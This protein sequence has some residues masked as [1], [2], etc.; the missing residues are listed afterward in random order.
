[1]VVPLAEFIF[2]S[3][4]S[5]AAPLMRRDT[6]EESRAQPGTKIPLP[7]PLQEYR[8]MFGWVVVFAWA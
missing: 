7:F 5:W 2:Q 1:M 3:Q 8:D 6:G 4:A